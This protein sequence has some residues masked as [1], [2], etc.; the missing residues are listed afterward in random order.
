VSGYTV[1]NGVAVKAGER[2][3][4]CWSSAN[5]DEATFPEPQEVRLDRKPNPHL[6]FGF[7]THLCLGAPHARL[8]LRTLLKLCCDRVKRITILKAEERVEHEA[9]FDRTL[10]YDSLVVKMTPL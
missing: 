8:I 5:F 4:L 9:K 10:G 1:V 7:G 6:S 2:I 3:S